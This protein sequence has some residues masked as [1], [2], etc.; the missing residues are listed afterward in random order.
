[1]KNW[2]KSWYVTQ[3]FFIVVACIV[4]ICIASILVPWLVHVA[5]ITCIVLFSSTIIETLLLYTG[6]GK[7][8]VTRSMDSRLSLGDSNVVTV[9]VENAYSF[10]VHATLLDEI[11]V[12]FQIR[13]FYVPLTLRSGARQKVQ[14]SIVPNDRGKFLYGSCHMFVRTVVGLAERRISSNAQ[15]EVVVYPSVIGMKNAEMMALSNKAYLYGTRKLR[16]IG[17]TL[18]FEQIKDY[19]IGDDVRNIN[20]KASARSTSIKI[21]LY[22]DERSQDVFSIIDA[23]RVMRMPFDGLTLLDYSVNAALAFSNV[24]LKKSDRVG[25]LTYNTTVL[26]RVPAQGT[27]K[28]LGVIHEQLYNIDTDYQ[29]SDD[30]ALVLGTRLLTRKRSLLML[31]TNIESVTSLKRRLPYLAAIAKSHVLVVVFF[32]NTELQRMADGTVKHLQDIY[33]KAVAQGLMQQKREVVALLKQAGVHTVFTKP[34]ELSL[35]SIQAYL[36]IKSRGI[37]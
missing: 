22:Q 27:I 13:D 20:W 3:R 31:Y 11:P 2:W 8:I 17:T 4:G 30:E 21:N 28:Q 6:S 9:T 15:A 29:E 36:R 26:N 1:M 18:E 12:E 10:A 7:V 37:I 33:Y 25:L 16:R 14:Y 23:G 34:K 5:M 24:V 32:E 19:V 35:K